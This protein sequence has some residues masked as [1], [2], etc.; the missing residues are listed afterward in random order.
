MSQTVQAS[1]LAELLL[2]QSRLSAG[3]KEAGQQL[4]SKFHTHKLSEW[5]L[6]SERKMAGEKKREKGK[7][8]LNDGAYIYLPTV[9]MRL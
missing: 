1:S 9:C 8:L 3:V 2:T 4:V 6:I 5:A 7:H